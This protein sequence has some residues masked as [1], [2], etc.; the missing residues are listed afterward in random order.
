MSVSQRIPTRM[1]MLDRMRRHKGWL[2]WSLALVVLTFVVFYI[3]DFLT[4]DHGRR[5]RPRCWPRSTASRSRWARSSA[6]TTRRCNAYRNAYGGQMNDA[7]AEA[8]GHRPP[9]PP[10]AGRRGG[11]GGRGAQA[12]HHRQR[13]RDSRAHPRPA[14]LPG[15][16]PVRRRAA[17][18]ADSPDPEPAAHDLRVR[19]EPA[20]RACRSRSCA[21]RS[22]TGCRSTDAE[23]AAEY[24]TP[25]REGQARRRAGHRRHLHE[26]GDS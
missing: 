9:D 18:P 13:R 20:P 14:G 7:A 10:A 2:K 17:L 26:P 1:T 8:A 5:A 22:P 24:R 21:P 25:Q 11:H 19:G 3:P 12:G 6:A 4:D 16:R 23:V 15:E